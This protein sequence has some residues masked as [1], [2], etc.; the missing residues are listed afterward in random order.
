MHKVVALVKFLELLKC[1][2]FIPL[3]MSV[4]CNCDLGL[5]L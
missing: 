5:H 1:V 3:H 4:W 2:S